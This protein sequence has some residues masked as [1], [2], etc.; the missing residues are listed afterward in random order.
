[1]KAKPDL[2]AALAESAGATRRRPPER[3]LEDAAP[4]T[5]PY[6]LRMPQEVHQQLMILAAE[7]GR[8]IND[9]M[10]EFL[11]DGF[12]KYG[13]PEIAPRKGQGAS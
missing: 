8:K 13:K 2:T 9:L 7:Q 5:M 10:F 12:A 4:R 11:N 3:P 6:Q 1:M